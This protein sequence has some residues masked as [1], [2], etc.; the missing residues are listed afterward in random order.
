MTIKKITGKLRLWLELSSGLVVCM[1]ANF[2][3]GFHGL[4]LLLKQGERVEIESYTLILLPET[5]AKTRKLG[6]FSFLNFLVIC[7]YDYENCFDTVLRHEHVHNSIL[8]KDR[9]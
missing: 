5:A 9:I 6:S 7:S 3:R 4:H 8:L 1:L 2:L